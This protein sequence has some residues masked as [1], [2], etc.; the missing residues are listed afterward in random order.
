MDILIACEE[1]QTVCKAFRNK[2]HNAYSCDLQSCSGGHP[3]WHIKQDIL[4]LLNGNCLFTT[5]DGQTHMQMGKW[6]MIIAHPPCTFLTIAG[7]PELAKHPER[8][9]KGVEAAEFLLAILNADCDKICIENPIP[10]KRFNLPKY[11]QLIRAYQIGENHNKAF[12]LW[13]KGDLP[14]LKVNTDAVKPKAEYVRIYKGKKKTCSDWHNH[15]GG[16]NH[17]VNR[18]KTPIGLAEIMAEQWG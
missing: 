17:R 10:M 6:D 18:S 13:L 3:E 5:E 14:V 1:S 2:G 8:Y 16:S 9:E 11:T 4:P 12:C 7:A 15:N